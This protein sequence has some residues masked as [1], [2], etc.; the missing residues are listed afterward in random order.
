LRKLNSHRFAPFVILHRNY[1]CFDGA[2]GSITFES[3]AIIKLQRQSG[4]KN[5]EIR[6]AKFERRCFP[7]FGAASAKCGDLHRYVRCCGLRKKPC[8]LLRATLSL[9][10]WGNSY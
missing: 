2:S 5:G 6:C 3:Y 7:Q 8:Q 10:R 1:R 4:N 9:I